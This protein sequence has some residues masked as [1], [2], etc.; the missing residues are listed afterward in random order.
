MTSF[1]YVAL[2]LPTIHPLY[3]QARNISLRLHQHFP[4]LKPLKPFRS[5]Y[6]IANALFGR[7]EVGERVEAIRAEMRCPE[8]TFIFCRHPF[9]TSR[10]AVYLHPETVAT[11]LR[12]KFNQYR[13]W[14]SAEDHKGWDAL[15][16]VDDGYFQ[17]SERYLP[18]F[19]KMDPK[20]VQIRVFRKG[21]LA[22]AW[23]VYRHYG[24]KGRFEGE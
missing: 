2:F 11:T 12:Y 1:M 5:K 20:P 7:E 13:F 9:A 16:V 22:Q 3:V 18:L 6:D 24:F 15:F 14:F 23:N 21:Q 10:L 17:R 19:R 4:T 8:R